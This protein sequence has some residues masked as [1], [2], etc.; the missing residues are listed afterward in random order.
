MVEG[1]GTNVNFSRL[2]QVEIYIFNSVEITINSRVLLHSII[3]H[4][5]YM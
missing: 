4:F 5:N 2:S 3:Y 1:G